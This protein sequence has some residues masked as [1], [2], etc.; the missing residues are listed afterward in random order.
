MESYETFEEECEEIR[1]ENK[2]LLKGFKAWLI[3]KNLSGKV[4]QK[5]CSNV[6]FYI[7]DFLLYEDTIRPADG[8]SEIGSFLGRWFIRKAMWASKTTIKENA[9]SLKKFYQFMLESNKVSKESLN[10]LK[11]RIKEEMPDWIA[12]VERYDDPEI[13]DMEEVWGY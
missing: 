13:E 7:N 4:I 3:K 12:T 5:H 2:I 10:E 8:A 6:D 9:S 11:E 1:K